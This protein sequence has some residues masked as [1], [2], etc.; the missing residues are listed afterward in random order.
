MKKI[1]ISVS[2]D[3]SFND[4]IQM[5]V[6]ED[7]ILHNIE[8]DCIIRIPSSPKELE[9]I[10]MIDNLPNSFSELGYKISTGPVV[11]HRSKDFLCK[12]LK[13]Q[14]QAPLI[15]MHNFEEYRVKWPFNKNKKKPEAITIKESSKKILIPIENYV[16]LKRFSSKEQNRRIHAAILLKSDLKKHDYVGIE[17]HI[18]YIYTEK[19]QLSSKEAFG[20]TAILNSS[21]YDIFFRT[22]DGT[23]QVNAN[24]IKNT[25]FPDKDTILNIGNFFLKEN[26]GIFIDSKIDEIVKRSILKNN[27]R[28]NQINNNT[29]RDMGDGSLT[30]GKTE[31]TIGILNK[32]GLPKAQQNDR[33]ARTILALLNLKESSEWL[34]SEQ[35]LLRVHDIISF[36]GKHYGMEYAENSRETIRRQTLH[37]FEQAGVVV[38]NPDKPERPT[39]SPKT[40]WAVTEE[41][42][43]LV[44]KY[45]TEKWNTAINNFIKN[46]GKLAE[47]YKKIKNKNKF[48]VDDGDITLVFSPGKHNKLQAKILSEL[49][50]F[51]FSKAKLLY[52]G[53]A[54]SKMLYF[55]RLLTG[56]L[57]IPITQHDK[58]PDVVYYDEEKDVLFLIEAVTSHGPISP[59]R[60]IELEEVLKNCKSKNIFITAFPDHKEFKKHI[61]D[62]AW[63]TEVWLSDQPGHMIH[64]NGP[65]FLKDM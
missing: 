30:M 54:S 56:K 9:I 34:D 20:I 42:L 53:D 45:E 18:N 7:I 52:V 8:D 2:K 4:L 16:L 15:W 17:N 40:V 60:Q 36:I 6:D 44:R 61:S 46:K 33:S 38:R 12:K 55:D 62:I 19:G 28:Q 47:K 26:N 64:F 25:P 13:N 23:T 39:N 31:E 48:T 51:F 29:E 37:Q 49:K 14:N 65:K 35:K 50:S 43:D 11:A 63:E 5:N 59:K 10:K 58:L 57:G 21:F 32:L 24:E 41:M 1:T 27:L 22:C 3:R